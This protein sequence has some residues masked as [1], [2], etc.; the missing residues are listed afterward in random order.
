MKRKFTLASTY[1]SDRND[2]MDKLIGFVQDHL[3]DDVSRLILDRKKW[4]EIDMELAVNCIESRRKLKGKVPEWYEH[5]A[6]LY[7]DGFYISAVGEGDSKLEAETSALATISMYF[8][9][10]TEVSNELER[11][12][13]EYDGKN[14]SFSFLCKC[15]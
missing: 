12:M 15:L 8:N 2:T 6:T 3:T 13:R 7:P 10:T 9:I 4:P 5:R 14:Y 1:S 11:K